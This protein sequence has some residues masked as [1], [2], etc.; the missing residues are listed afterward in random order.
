M[1]KRL[2]VPWWDGSTIGHLVQR[3]PLYF[4]YDPEWTARGLDLSPISLPFGDVA[5]NGIKGV[6][7]LPGLLAD[8]LPDAWGRRVARRAAPC[9]RRS[10]FYMRIGACAWANLPKMEDYRAF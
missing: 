8:C 9:Q 7:G 2:K 6:E 1:E 10:C 5:Y 3:G 4:A